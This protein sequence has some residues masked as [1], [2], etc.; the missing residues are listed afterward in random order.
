MKCNVMDYRATN[1]KMLLEQGVIPNTQEN[2]QTIVEQ[3]LGAEIVVMAY[4]SLHKKLAHHGQAV[5]DALRAA[6][7]SCTP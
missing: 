4:G 6:K 2:L 3:A 7:L 1:P 5:T